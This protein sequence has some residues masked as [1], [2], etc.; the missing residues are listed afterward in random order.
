MTNINTNINYNDSRGKI[1]MVLEDCNIGSISRI[2]TY[3]NNGRAGHYHKR[4][5]HFIIINEGQIEIYER[6][7]NS[8]EKPIKTILNKGDIHYTGPM[9]E[10]YMWM[11]CFTIFDCYSLLKRTSQNYEEETVRFEH[12]LKDIYDEK[13]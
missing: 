2:E 12:N 5:S 9:V 1:Q 8:S 4:D 11:P 13:I 10:H 6:P 7:V 3:P